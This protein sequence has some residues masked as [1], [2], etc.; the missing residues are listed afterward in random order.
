[1]QVFVRHILTAYA[2]LI[3]RSVLGKVLQCR[4]Q[5]HKIRH[6]C[7]DSVYHTIV[8]HS[9]FHNIILACIVFTTTVSYNE[10]KPVNI[11]FHKTFIVAISLS[12][13]E[14]EIIDTDHTLCQTDTSHAV[15]PVVGL[16]L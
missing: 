14:V 16:L 11:V 12:R 4:F 3:V 6:I 5:R 1:M 7:L 9:T 2:N 8:C 13:F 15:G 10:V